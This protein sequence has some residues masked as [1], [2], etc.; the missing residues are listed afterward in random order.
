MLIIMLCC[1]KKKTLFW[2]TL[3]KS[4]LRES[5]LVGLSE[6][7]LPESISYQEVPLQLCTMFC[8]Y[9]QSSIWSLGGM[10][11]LVQYGQMYQNENL[12]L[13]RRESDKIRKWKL[14]WKTPENA[15]LLFMTPKTLTR[16]LCLEHE[17]ID[18]KFWH[19]WDHWGLF[20]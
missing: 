2:I 14:L 12:V 16:S 3:R 15:D 1:W 17:D 8:L 11:Y 20:Q 18:F 4:L 13:Q 19:T 7:G 9:F 6:V 10:E 5:Y